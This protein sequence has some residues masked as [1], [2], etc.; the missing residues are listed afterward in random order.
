MRVVSITSV[1]GVSRVTGV[2][3][4]L[5][6]DV[7]KGNREL[8]GGGYVEGGFGIPDSRHTA[9]H[10]LIVTR[11]LGTI[12]WRLIEAFDT[13]DGSKVLGLLVDESRQRSGGSVH[14]V[15]V[16]LVPE[17]GRRDA[18]SRKGVGTGLSTRGR[19]E[20]DKDGDTS[21]FEHRGGF[22]L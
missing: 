8:R 3:L 2:V 1:L 16:G 15:E 22:G 21:S 17:A 6:A 20:I 19:V 11:S 14:S 9:L 10:K 5:P 13:P 7:H 4:P 18:V 12:S